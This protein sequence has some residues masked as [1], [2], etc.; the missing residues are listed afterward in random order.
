ML[1]LSSLLGVAWRSLLY[2]F[3]GVVLTVVSVAISVFVLLG[4]EHVRQ[5]ARNGFA[6]TVSGVDL[7][8]GA[9]TGEVNL[10]LLSVFRIGTPTAN[11]SWSSLEQIEAQKNVDWTVPISLGDSHRGFRVV[12]TTQ[13]FLPATSTQTDRRWLFGRVPSL[14][15]QQTWYSARALQLSCLMG[16]VSRLC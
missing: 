5:E 7:I 2:R 11:V 9:R 16:W 1:N 13:E 15:G 12:G 10:L 3:S 4:V 8:V 6:S 14:A